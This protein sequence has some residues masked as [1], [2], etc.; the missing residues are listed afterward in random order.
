MGDNVIESSDRGLVL[1]TVHDHNK[2]VPSWAVEKCVPPGKNAE[3]F[4]LLIDWLMDWL[5]DLFN[6]ALSLAA[7]QASFSVQ[8]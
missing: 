7:I 8:R 2:P 5:I 1:E 3:W 6:D 4:K